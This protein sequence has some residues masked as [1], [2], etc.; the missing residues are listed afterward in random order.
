MEEQNIRISNLETQITELTE[1]LKRVQLDIVELAKN[2]QAY[3]ILNN[4]VE[5][6]IDKLNEGKNLEKI[7]SSGIII[8]PKSTKPAI[9]RPD[10]IRKYFISKMI[11]NESINIQKKRKDGS[12]FSAN[13]KYSKVFKV[14]KITDMISDANIE[15]LDKL[16][17]VARDKK[18]AGY[19]W[20]IINR[21]KDEIPVCKG[22][23]TMVS[24]EHENYKNKF[25]LNQQIDEQNQL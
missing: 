5:D 1:Q 25:Q 18:E 7:K 22:M 12:R 10:P 4:I 9:E 2:N 16:S 17:G 14:K 24:T 21:N 15:A 19:I 6:N 11:N 23:Y 8:P 20:D 3:A 13:V